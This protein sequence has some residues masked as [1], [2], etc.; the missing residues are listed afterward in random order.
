MQQVKSRDPQ[1]SQRDPRCYQSRRFIQ[2]AAPTTCPECGAPTRMDM[3]RKVDPDRKTILEYRTCT[4]CGARLA[5]GRAM[6]C[7][8]VK[9]FCPTLGLPDIERN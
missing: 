3:G 1:P 5:A 2:A 7:Y 6:T 9:I 8:E 4:C